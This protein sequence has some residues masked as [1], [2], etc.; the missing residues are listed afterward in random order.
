MLVIRRSPRAF[1]RRRDSR[2]SPP[3]APQ[4]I[5]RGLPIFC[6]IRGKLIRETLSLSLAVSVAIFQPDLHFSQIE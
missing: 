5:I 6:L 3:P 1:C 4:P 2:K